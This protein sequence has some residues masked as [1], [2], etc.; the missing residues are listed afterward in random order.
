MPPL[1]PLGFFLGPHRRE[2]VKLRPPGLPN[3]AQAAGS[4]SRRPG[5]ELPPPWPLAPR[6]LRPFICSQGA[7]SR[8]TTPGQHPL[9][10]LRLVGAGCKSPDRPQSSLAPAAH[11]VA[12]VSEL[13]RPLQAAME[14]L[15]MGPELSQHASCLAAS[16]EAKL[17]H[18]APRSVSLTVCLHFAICKMG[19]GYSL[20][21]A[22]DLEVDT[23]GP[24]G[25]GSAPSKGLVLGSMCWAVLVGS[26][27]PQKL[28]IPGSRWSPCWLCGWGTPGPRLEAILVLLGQLCVALP[29]GPPTHPAPGPV[30]AVRRA[31]LQ[32]RKRQSQSRHSEHIR[33]GH[34]TE[35]QPRP[36]GMGDLPKTFKW[37]RAAWHGLA[38][39]GPRRGK[40]G[41]GLLPKK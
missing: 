23:H 7:D 22:C 13:P 21:E 39:P 24:P 41:W 33:Q 11:T 32:S 15:Q 10:S 27:I 31:C 16:L 35:G 30:N 26:W 3:Q 5:R 36:S 37:A 19:R 28:Q 25:T 29:C 2:G 17:S 12:A 9:P 34:I 8:W 4:P 6:Q 14:Q 20:S 18:R 40:A 1:W 38:A